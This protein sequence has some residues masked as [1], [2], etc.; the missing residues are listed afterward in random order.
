MSDPERESRLTAAADQEPSA[1]CRGQLDRF[2]V[3]EIS[4][5][6]MRDRVLR[7]R[8][9]EFPLLTQKINYSDGLRWKNPYRGGIFR[10]RTAPS[11]KTRT[12]D[13]TRNRRYKSAYKACFW[14]SQAKEKASPDFRQGLEISV[15]RVGSEGR[16]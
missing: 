13:S 14:R 2:V 9:A 7:R 16:I 11:A 1:F 5:T 3:G 12:K 6:E 15:E 10:I 8:H 4:A